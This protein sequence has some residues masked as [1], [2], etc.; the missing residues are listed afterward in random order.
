MRMEGEGRVLIVSLVSLRNESFGWKR[1]GMRIS[2][3]KLGKK[4]VWDIL[5]KNEFCHLTNEFN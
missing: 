1:T 4:T 3:L 2:R 5:H